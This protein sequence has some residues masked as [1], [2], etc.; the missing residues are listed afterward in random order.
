M[1][2]RPS[3]LEAVA[4]LRAVFLILAA[5]PILPVG[6]AAAE[7]NLE[8]GHALLLENCARCHA[9]EATGASPLAIAPPFRTLHERYPLEDLEEA[10]AEGII[11]G[12]PAM[13]ELSFEPEDIDD[14]IA[15]LKSLG[16]H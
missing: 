2:R 13:P 16:G 14:I 5:G 9:T 15:Y 3:R 6:P 12:H 4:I 10:L 8:H 7:P 1:K 11:T